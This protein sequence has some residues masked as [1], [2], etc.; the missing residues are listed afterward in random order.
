MKK[1]FIV[2]LGG[3]VI[4]DKGKAKT[5]NS[6]N[7]E[8]LSAEIA[9]ALEREKFDLVIIHGGGSFGHSEAKKYRVHER[10]SSFGWAATHA[11][12]QE[13]NLEVIHALQRKGLNAIEF[14]TSAVAAKKAGG[15][16]VKSM[17]LLEE[18]LRHGLIPVGYGDV[19]FDDGKGCSILSGDGLAT[20][21]ARK[22]RAD[23]V[24]FCSDVDGVFSADPGA[25]RGAKLIERISRKN[26]EGVALGKSR[27]TD[28]TGGMRNK[29]S[30]LLKLTGYGIKS[31]IING[32]K[33][34]MLKKALLSEKHRGTL[35]E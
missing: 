5:V 20:H 33:P 31:E 6:K 35:I 9:S 15:V 29:V 17:V 21:F 10:L 16:E 32:L 24:I 12:M 34:G 1:L 25:G 8:R 19:V 7:L 26:I 4:T 30:E 14:Q 2:K 18:F 3:S 23:R 11:A 22:L 28:V 27:K 13:L